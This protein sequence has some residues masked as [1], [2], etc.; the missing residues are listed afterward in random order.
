MTEPDT[1]EPVHTRLPPK[2]RREAGHLPAGP[3]HDALLQLA[4]ELDATGGALLVPHA[5]L[6]AALGAFAGQV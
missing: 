5:A 2:L 4:D 1:I 3:G 6:R